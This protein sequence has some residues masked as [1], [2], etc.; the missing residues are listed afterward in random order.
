MGVSGAGKTTIGKLLGERLGWPFYDGDD[1]HPP[2]NIEKMS[3]NIPLTDEDRL[4]WLNRLRA[5]ATEQIEK[6]PNA[7][8]ACSA[9]KKTYR[10]ILAEGLDE[11]HFVHLKGSQSLILDRMKK[12]KG[13]YMKADLLTSQFAALEESEHIFTIDI[14][15][16]P[17]EIAGEIIKNFRLAI[18]N[19]S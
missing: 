19:I 15:G 6:R 14:S 7:I 2:A 13:H 18:N 10:R 3:R 5:L 9:L 11:V 16:E 4:P 12:R 1:F 17:Q 8:I